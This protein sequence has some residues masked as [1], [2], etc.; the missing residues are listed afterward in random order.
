LEEG[1]NDLT[2]ALRK[3]RHIIIWDNFESAVGISGT[4]ISAS[5]S[6]ADLDLLM[7]FLDKLRSGATKVLITSRSAED[8]LGP[9]RRLILRLAGLDTQERWDFCELLVKNLGLKVNRDDPA[10]IDLINDLHG[11]PLAMRVVL[12]QLNK[13]SAAQLRNVLHE[14]TSKLKW[15]AEGSDEAMLFATIQ[16]A[17]HCVPPELRP[18]LTLLA[19]HRGFFSLPHLKLMAEASGRQPSDAEMLIHV[20]ASAG[21][22][23]HVGGVIY[24]MHPMLV[25]YLSSVV[26]KSLS[27][28]DQEPFVQAFVD[29]TGSMADNVTFLGYEEKLQAYY[30]LGESIYFALLQAHT[31]GLVIKVGCLTQCLAALAQ[32]SRDF[33]TA[34]KL[35]EELAEHANRI[36]FPEAEAAARHQLGRVA[37]AQ[38]D[39]VTAEE[40]YRAAISLYEQVGNFKEVTYNYNC[41]GILNIEQDRF[42]LASEWYEK[43][44][45]LLERFPKD[46]LKAMALHGV[47]VVA[48]KRREL[49]KAEQYFMSELRL[50]KQEDAIGAIY[51]QL[52]R[53]AQERGD[54]P[55]ATGWFLKSLQIGHPQEMELVNTYH[56]LAVIASQ[57]KDVTAAR[58]WCTSCLVIAERW[59]DLRLSADL[60]NLMGVITMQEEDFVASEQWFYKTIPIAEEKKMLRSLAICYLHL[61]ILSARKKHFV[62]SGN[63]MIKAVVAST[64]LGDA[65]LVTTV[66]DNFA[67][68]YEHAPRDQQPTLEGMWRDAGLGVLPRTSIKAA[69][70]IA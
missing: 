15:A 27:A 17:E 52:G 59:N 18:L 37:Q 28:D 64:H 51:H 60:Y 13:T 8:W 55:K 65:E 58:H 42:Q 32:N 3:T 67:V 57:Q 30:Y 66:S 49:E 23:T 61:G 70:Q 31:R 41:L 36:R 69:E 25:G 2:A 40:R 34:A 43:A 12:L 9:E 11:H 68:T 7:R 48:L 33:D 26:L 22:V 21:L 50:E 39:F 14:N 38:A 19:I 4:P 62:E 53:V 10:L 47:G 35:Y 6:K 45:A 46:E 5:L 16:L 44:L 29:V 56:Q 20:L 54:Y 63:W 24:E 1:L